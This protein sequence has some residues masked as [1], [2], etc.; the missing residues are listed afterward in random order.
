[1]TF[2]DNGT[3]FPPKLPYKLP[4]LPGGKQKTANIGGYSGI[5]FSKKIDDNFSESGQSIMNINVVDGRGNEI[6]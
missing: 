3:P 4:K 6:E 2:D 1:M 5:D